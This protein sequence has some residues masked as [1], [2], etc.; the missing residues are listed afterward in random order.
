[1]WM[2]VYGRSIPEMTCLNPLKVQKPYI[3]IHNY[4]GTKL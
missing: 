2:T 4:N 3:S 1:M